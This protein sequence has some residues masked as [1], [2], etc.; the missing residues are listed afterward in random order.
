MN[1]PISIFVLLCLFAG[2]ATTSKRCTTGGSSEEKAV[3]ASTAS[4]K[5][6][7]AAVPS[8]AG[9]ED[10]LLAGLESEYK[11]E[12][13]AKDV[14]D[15]KDP[16]KA[17][18]LVWFHFNDKLYLWVIRPVA[19]GYGKVVPKPARNGINN[20]FTNLKTPVPLVS[21]FLQGR[22]KDLGVVAARFGINSTAGLLGF[23][24]VAGKE[25]GLAERNEDMD[26]A[27]GS[28]GIGTGYYLIWPFYGPS[29]VRGTFGLAGDMVLDPIMWIPWPR[30]ASAATN[31]VNTINTASFNPNQYKELKGAAMA[32]YIGLRQAYYENR[33]KLVAE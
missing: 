3:Q 26:Q 17:W 29:S 7:E 11:G 31:A 22:W 32:P 8:Q 5:E 12:K 2:C 20:F 30:A 16:L 15:M 9:P 10:A 18:N 23:I 25:C 28:W 27:F 33:K 1:K 14:K 4:S 21:C 6:G 19:I 24:D 13:G